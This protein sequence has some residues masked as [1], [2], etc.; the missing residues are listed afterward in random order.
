MVFEN[1]DAIESMVRSG[2]TD[3]LRSRIVPVERRPSRTGPFRS[4]LMVSANRT[5]HLNKLDML[6]ADAAILNLEDGVAPE[7][8][9]SALLLAALFLSHLR[10]SKSL[11]VVRVN[12]LDRGGLEEIRVL[13]RVKPHA[14][15]IP[16]VR[17]LHDVELA[18]RET[19][20]DIDIHLSIETAESFRDMAQLRPDRRVTTFYLGILDLLASLGLPQKILS[21]GNPSVDYLLSRFLIES[22]TLGVRPVSFV[23]Q[24]FRDLETFGLWCERERSMGYAAKGC[25]SPDQVAIANRIFGP[26]GEDLRRARHIIERFEEMRSLGTTG[27]VDELYG[28]IDEPIYR[29]A[30]GVIGAYEEGESAIIL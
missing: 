14:I 25:I 21:P 19:D 9:E 16:K 23:Y 6:P 12:P 27:F 5:K 26:D 30:L 8:K 17:S 15:R 28:F 3:A 18:L 29:D 4:A 13:N 20:S 22:R 2:D 7:E 1:L 11:L 24:D 10:E